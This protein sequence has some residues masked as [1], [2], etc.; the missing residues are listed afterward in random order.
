MTPRPTPPGRRPPPPR[1]PAR[2]VLLLQD[3]AH[4]GTQRQSLELARRLDPALFT[5]EIW[6]LMAGQDLA[7]RARAWGVPVRRLGEAGWVTPASLARL[8]RALASEPVDLLVLLTVVPNIWGRLLGRPARVPVI[9]ATCR[10]GASIRRQ[11]EWLLHRLADHIICNSRRLQERLRAI[12]RTRPR[13]VS[14]IDNGV[15]T[16][17]LVPGPAGHGPDGPYLLCLARLAP[18]KDHAT[19]LRA[20]ALLAERW[21]AARLKLAG[22]GPGRASLAGLA[23]SLGIAGRVEFLGPVADPAPLLQGARAVVLS[24]RREAMPNAVLEAM[25][26]G[27]PV[28]ATRVGAL[29]ELVEETGAGVLA[30]PGDPRALAAAMEQVLAHPDRAAAWGRAGRR[31]AVERYSLA[32]MVQS[33]QE[34]FLRLLAGG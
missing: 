13:A 9:V 16:E 8:G 5:V 25:A 26:C 14:R 22:D 31:A 17:R 2:V 32:A 18:D 27:R 20:F 12:Y 4:G 10:G 1:G 29:P 7:S 34:L 21:P 23:G 30:P 19:L 33:H 6:T 28:V 15:D 24:S 3:L 11:H